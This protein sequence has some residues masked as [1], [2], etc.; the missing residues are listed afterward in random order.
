[1]YSISFS[2]KC[3][4]CHYETDKDVCR[5]LPWDLSC[6]FIG[7]TRTAAM[8]P[9]INQAWRRCSVLSCRIP[10]VSQTHTLTTRKQNVS[11][12]GYGRGQHSCDKALT[13]S[14]F[15]FQP[16]HAG[17][18]WNKYQLTPLG[19][20]PNTGRRHKN[21]QQA[22]ENCSC[23]A[24]NMLIMWANWQ[25]KMLSCSWTEKRATA[26]EILSKVG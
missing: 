24:S 2:V 4:F 7:P 21:K 10:K 5:L 8:A 13:V 18:C 14:P 11:G 17:S 15:S 22:G 3:L 1:M 12:G 9:D 20:E 25:I 23:S 26:V 6:L 19:H 16:A